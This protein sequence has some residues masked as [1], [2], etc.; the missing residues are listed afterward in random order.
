MEFIRQNENVRPTTRRVSKPLSASARRLALLKRSGLFGEYTHGTK[1]TRACSLEELRQAY[2]L[3][4]G[5][6]LEAGYIRPNSYGIRV[7]PFEA[8]TESATFVAKADEEVVAALSLI[9]DSVD[10]GLP[11]DVSF[12][13]ELDEMRARGLRLSET[14]NQAVAP[15]LRNTA[16]TTNLMRCCLAQAMFEDR[17]L[18]VIAISPSHM[19][20]YEL[21]GFRRRTDVRN[22]S[23]EVHDPVVMMSLDVAPFRR[24]RTGTT[25]TQAFIRDF[26]SF[27]NPFHRRIAEWNQSAADAF[28][29]AD[30]LRTLFVQESDLFTKCTHAELD[31]LRRRWGDALFHEVAGA[32]LAAGSRSAYVPVGSHE[33]ADKPR[34]VKSVGSAPVTGDPETTP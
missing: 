12:R 21:L 7:R 19:S 1:I 31:G 13:P 11:L 15:I 32:L 27:R 2:R 26:L 9:V 8:T 23:D 18:V 33:P 17:D 5:S 4:Y 10:L 3:V 24:R 34:R 30:L 25:P 29:D 16:V 20:F 14:S 28:R 22:Y 6:F